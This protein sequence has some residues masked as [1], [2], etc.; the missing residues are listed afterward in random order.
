[1][2]LWEILALAGSALAGVAPAFAEPVSQAIGTVDGAEAAF[3]RMT[4]LVG[5]WRVADKPQSPLRIRFSLTAGGTVLVEEWLR[6]DK[7][8]SLTLY[9]RDGGHLMA[10]HYCPQGN[11]PRLLAMPTH[12]S[13]TIE[14]RFLDAADLD[15]ASES[16]LVALGFDFGQPGQLRRTETYRAAN[17]DEP[18]EL[19]LVRDSE[20][21]P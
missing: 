4:G 5:T 19:V 21:T 15:P 17:G 3:D 6:G 18:S 20:P 14:W 9:H 12:G 7:P 10:V 11:Q 1:M 16:Y 13:R 2:A 8:H